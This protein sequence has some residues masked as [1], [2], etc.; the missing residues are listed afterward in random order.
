MEADDVLADEVVIDRPALGELFV[1]G[2]VTVGG[3]VVGER[4]E[5]YICDVR[6]I[7]RQRD[8]PSERLA[9][10]GEVVEARLDEADHLVHAVTRLDCVRML[11]V[12][13]E[14]SLLEARE[15]K[16]VVL[17]FDEGGGALVD[18]AVAVDEFFFD[19]VRLA[20]H[21]VLSAVYV[22]FDVAGIEACL[23]QLLY[24]HAVAWLSGADEVVVGD[25]ESLPRLFEQG[26]D[27]V[28]ELL[29]RNALGVGRLL[30]LQAVL[31]GSRE[32]MHVFAEQAVPAGNGVGDDRGVC[33]AEVW[34]GVD[35][36]DGSRRAETVRRVVRHRSTITLGNC[37]L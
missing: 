16:E 6:R 15:P 35:V 8:A 29:W 24:A 20:R 3:D 12:P 37:H 33:V 23:Q 36:I 5:P 17:F 32:Q 11:G 9:T 10:D 34:L 18:G 21:A 25:V 13:V 26:G 31:V 19:E 30:N 7:P 28:G 2:A 27:L 14:Q 1:V 4:V 22:E